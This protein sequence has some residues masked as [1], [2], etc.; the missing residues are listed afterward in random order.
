MREKD[1]STQHIY[2]GVQNNKT[3]GAKN[4]VSV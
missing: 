1:Y 2:W 4:Y 3:G